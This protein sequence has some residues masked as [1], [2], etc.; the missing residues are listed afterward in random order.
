MTITREQFLAERAKGIGGSDIAAVVGEDPRKTPYQLWREKRGMPH[1]E[2]KRAATRRGHFLEAAILNRY[3]TIVQPAAL[4]RAVQHCDGWRRGNQDARATMSDGRRIVVEAKSVSRNV[5]RYTSD[6]KHSWGDPWSDE[7]PRRALCQG[8]WYG[9]L[10]DAQLIDFAVMVVPDDPD[11]VL[12]LSADEIVE[13]SEFHV[14]RA[15][16]SAPVEEYLV[17]AAED[18]WLN[19]VLAGVEPEPVNEDDV[20]LRW[21]THLAGQLA[22][23]TPEIERVLLD[24]ERE[25]QL[26]K[27]HGEQ[28]A[29]L[30]EKLMLFARDAEAI[31]GPDGKTPYM[32]LKT[33]N[34]AA[35]QRKESTARPLRFTSWWTKHHDKI[36]ARNPAPGAP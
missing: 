1:P 33:H 21:P 35:H 11:E 28:A 5:F 29:K 9:A 15:G 4:D 34:V 31:A 19:C 26:G 24:Y 6:P 2:G 10:D 8:L 3:A 7:V 20:D 14:F 27:E 36:V 18:F 13:L 23:A 17:E 30:H 22:V 25:K 16:R 12:G 32:T